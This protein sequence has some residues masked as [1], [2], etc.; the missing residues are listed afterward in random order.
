[1]CVTHLYICH[2]YTSSCRLTFHFF[3]QGQLL[4]EV[5]G[6]SGKS[7]LRNNQLVVLLL[8]A[9]T[10]LPR[11]KILYQRSLT[12]LSAHPRRRRM[13]SLVPRTWYIVFDRCN[14]PR[15][16]T[17]LEPQS[18][19]GDKSLGVRLVCPQIGTAVLKGL[20]LRSSKEPRKKKGEP[21]S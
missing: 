14:G 21:L 9:Q 13:R 16:L 5:E 11:I 6:F 10:R 7:S 12:T 15:S 1:M 2:I 19:F 18:R 4:G 17:L 3:S 20:R 8:T